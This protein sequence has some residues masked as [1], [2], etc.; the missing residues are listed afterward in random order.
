MTDIHTL[1]ARNIKYYRKLL[2]ISQMVLAARVGCST[3]LIGNIEIKKC[4]PSPKNINRIAQAL[5]IQPSDLF[6]DNAESIVPLS[7]TKTQLK[8]EIKSIL[9]KKILET[10]K[11]VLEDGE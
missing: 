10:L 2:G 4:F 11:E 6:T 9:E 5:E 1:L 8:K 7:V 3:T